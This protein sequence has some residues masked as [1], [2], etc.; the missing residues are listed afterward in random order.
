MNKKLLIIPILVAITLIYFLQPRP[1][2]LLENSHYIRITEDSPEKDG[3][4][5]AQFTETMTVSGRTDKDEFSDHA[6]KELELQTYIISF[7]NKTLVIDRKTLLEWWKKTKW[8][9]THIHKQ[10]VLYNITL[11]DQNTITPTFTI[12]PLLLKNEDGVYFRTTHNNAHIFCKDY[13]NNEYTCEQNCEKLVIPSH[14]HTETLNGIIIEFNMTPTKY[15]VFPRDEGLRW[16]RWKVTTTVYVPKGY[17]SPQEA[18]TEQNITEPE[19]PIIENNSE[20]VGSSPA[21]GGQTGQD[22][23]LL[24]LLGG[25]AVLIP[26]LYLLYKNQ[27]FL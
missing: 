22:S 21:G 2:V 13:C 19:E 18:N 7:S 4:Y 14:T 3:Y 5:I 1:T 9:K 27:K 8:L 6:H 20:E 24:L 25:L 15:H 11:E 23:T 26:A 10:Y 12:E 17:I 16:F